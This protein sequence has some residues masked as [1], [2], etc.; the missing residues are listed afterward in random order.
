MQTAKMPELKGKYLHFMDEGNSRCF[1]MIPPTAC[2]PTK[3]FSPETN[4]T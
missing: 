4:S 3:G 1:M 2:K